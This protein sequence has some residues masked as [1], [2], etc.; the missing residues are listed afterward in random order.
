MKYKITLQLDRAEKNE[1]IRAVK[2]HPFDYE[3]NIW[4]RMTETELKDAVVYCLASTQNRVDAVQKFHEA[5]KGRRIWEKSG[6]DLEKLLRRHRLRFPKK[7]A[8]WIAALSGA[9]IKAALQRVYARSRPVGL[10]SSREARRI[11]KHE[12]AIKGLG[13]K[14]MS[15][16]LSK[17][18][19]YTPW[20]VP[21]DSRWTN[22]LGSRGLF[23][24]SDDPRY[25][26]LE[27]LVVVLA[28]ELGVKPA[29]L[30]QAVWEM[31]A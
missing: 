17:W 21:L 23:D 10:Q 9:D 30:D 4:R 29:Y 24:E 15:H 2:S 14:Q 19:G 22:F 31:M 12:L 1:L 27:D 16:L 20:L 25:L 28:H 3:Q 7:K 11:L 26:L 13:D 18:L 8:K 5:T 6:Y